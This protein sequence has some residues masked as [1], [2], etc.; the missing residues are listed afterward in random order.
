MS[1]NGWK[2]KVI[3]LNGKEEFLQMGINPGTDAVFMLKSKAQEQASFLLEGIRED[4][5]S[6]NVVP[7]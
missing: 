3:W 6:I 2:V 5:Q 7:A 4:V 1:R